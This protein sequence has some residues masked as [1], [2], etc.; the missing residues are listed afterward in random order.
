MVSGES[1][2]ALISSSND[3]SGFT[4][5]GNGDIELSTL[6]TITG[7][8]ANVRMPEA[9]FLD[10]YE[11]ITRHSLNDAVRVAIAGMRM[12]GHEPTSEETL[13]ITALLSVLK[14]NGDLFYGDQEEAMLESTYRKLVNREETYEEAAARARAF[15]RVDYSR[16][17][18]RKKV[19][20]F[21]E[22]KGYPKV[23]QRQRYG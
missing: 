9:T 13:R 16:D 6:V 4:L 8:R 18:W 3:T 21:A 7:V 20:R 17:T 2:G 22:R 10:F 19:T 15:L 5:Y 1:D 12:A 14:S 23:G 11:T